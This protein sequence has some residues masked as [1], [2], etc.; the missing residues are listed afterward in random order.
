MNKHL[1]A[2]CGRKFYHT[3]EVLSSFLLDFILQLCYS[4]VSQKDRV[5]K[6]LH[7]GWLPT[8]GQ[9]KR[10]HQHI[11][12]SFGLKLGMGQMKAVTSYITN[13]YIYITVKIILFKQSQINFVFQC[14][15]IDWK[16]VPCND[17]LY[18]EIRKGS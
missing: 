2:V 12:Y 14:A 18:I 1:L 16:M 11:S 6:R 3:C 10:L 8:L 7:L 15:I 13:Y 4:Y 5:W 17:I 9:W